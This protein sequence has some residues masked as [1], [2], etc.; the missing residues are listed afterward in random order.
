M[1]KVLMLTEDFTEEYKVMVPFQA[2]EKEI[3]I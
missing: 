1:R 3:Y 2:L